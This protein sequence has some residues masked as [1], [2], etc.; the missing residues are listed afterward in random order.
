M[1]HARLASVLR[2]MRTVVSLQA[3]RG[4][5]DSALLAAFI[6]DQDEAAFA[7]L[8]QRHG[9]MVLGVC[10][11]VLGHEQDAEDAYQATFLVLA[12]KARSIRARETLSNWLYGV[13]FR[14]AMRAKRDA[15]RRRLWE[16]QGTTAAPDNPVWKAAWRE[17][18]AILDEDSP[19]TQ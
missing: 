7:A 8:V 6:S 4:Q 10:R 17:I 1:A 2:H 19:S 13:A 9:R 14:T 5:T 18:Q 15:A 12:R 11:H 3:H 16:T